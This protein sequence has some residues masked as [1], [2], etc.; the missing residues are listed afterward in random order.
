MSVHRSWSHMKPGSRTRSR[1][2]LRYF[3]RALQDLPR[4]GDEAEALLDVPHRGLGAEVGRGRG[5]AILDQHAAVAQEVGVGQR[6]QHALV[7]VDAG[8]QHGARAEVAQDGIERRVPEA[9]DAMLVDLDV[10][11]LLLELVDHGGC[12]GVLLQHRRAV[13]RH[14]VA[15]ADAA[16][17]RACRDGSGWAAC[18][19]GPAGAP[20]D[21]DHRHA[22]LA[23]RRQELLQR[24]DRLAVG[25]ESTP[26]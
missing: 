23:Q 25:R 4:I 2:S 9:A 7:G 3:F 13:A 19:R 1:K 17:G 22:R 21:P 20:V 24:L 26:R 6:V 18:W 14:R 12:P 10:L 8:E 16:A 5:A 11:G 15:Q